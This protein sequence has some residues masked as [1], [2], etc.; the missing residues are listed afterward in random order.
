MQGAVEVLHPQRK[1]AWRQKT[2]P[3]NVAGLNL[4]EVR[5][6]DDNK[7]ARSIA[8]FYTWSSVADL[9]VSPDQYHSAR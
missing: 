9:D 6:Q 1:R 4:F 2:A 8:D 5:W 7:G 3:W